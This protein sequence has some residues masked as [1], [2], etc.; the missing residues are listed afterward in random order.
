ML[1]LALALAAD[2]GPQQVPYDELVA[3]IEARRHQGFDDL[4]AARRTLR[5]AI[6]RDLLPRWTGTPW[7]FYGD[8]DAPGGEPVACGYYVSAILRDAGLRVER[9]RLAQQ[10][11]EHIIQTFVPEARIRRFRD[12]P[13]SEVVA[14][15]ARRDGVWIVG[16]DVHVG[17]LIAE[18]GQVRFCHSTFLDE[19]GA[20]CE[21]PLTSP[22]FVSRY[23][24]VGELLGDDVVQGWVDGRSWTTVTRSRR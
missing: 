9:V 4:P 10:A 18:G 2:V 14:H 21:D 6:V 23:R 7:S 8:A 20:T 11:S 12:R 5:D 19:A 24:V 22:A 15:V 1:W 13:A 16:L 3:S 17:F